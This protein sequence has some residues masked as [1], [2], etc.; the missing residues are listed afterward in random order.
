MFLLRGLAAGKQLVR[1]I[2]KY[3][4]KKWLRQIQRGAGVHRGTP[5][6][7]VATCR[8]HDDGQRAVGGM[9]PHELQHLDAVHV[10]HIEVE[11]HQA[12]RHEYPLIPWPLGND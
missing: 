8:Q 2:G 3:L 7:V 9:A 11:D 5:A 10:G 1:T 6:L 4:R 12:R